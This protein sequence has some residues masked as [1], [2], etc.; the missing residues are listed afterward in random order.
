MHLYTTIND[1]EKYDANFSLYHRPPKFLKRESG[2]IITV[3]AASLIVAFIYPVVYWTLSYAQ[4]FQLEYLKDKFSE[5]HNIRVTR[6]ATLKNRKADKD[7]ILTLLNEEKEDFNS[8]KN[9]L[10]KIKEVKNNYL[11]KAKELATFTKDLNKFKVKLESLEYKEENA[12]KY[13]NFHLVSAKSSRITN[14]VQYITKVYEN[15]YKFELNEIYF[16]DESKVYFSTL[17]AIK[18]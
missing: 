5:I 2:K 18:L 1:E 17:K 8:K 7:K 9:T 16:D 3:T 14:L 10:L 6:E 15:D 4:N 11:M 13:F 12:T